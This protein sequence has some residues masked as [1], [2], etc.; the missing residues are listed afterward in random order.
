[1]QWE[2]NWLDIF[3]CLCPG[4]PNWHSLPKIKEEDPS[5]YL[6]KSFRPLFEK[7]KQFLRN[8]DKM[9][10][11]IVLVLKKLRIKVKGALVRYACSRHY[12]IEAEGKQFMDWLREQYLKYKT[13][14]QQNWSGKYNGIYLSVTN[15]SARTWMTIEVHRLCFRDA[16]YHISVS[17]KSE[18]RILMSITRNGKSFGLIATRVKCG[19]TLRWL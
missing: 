13:V 2:A 6:E 11:T 12:L 10:N 16:D 8:R 4:E 17:H 19:R 18:S 5:D 1:M 3:I 9:S 15:Y 7:M 14:S